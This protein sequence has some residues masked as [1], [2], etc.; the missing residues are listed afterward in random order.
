[1]STGRRLQQA[2]RREAAMQDAAI[3][4]FEEDLRRVLTLASKRLRAL[5]G[6]WQA[7][8]KGRS[9]AIQLARVLALRTRARQVLRDAGFD[10]LAVS[11]LGDPLERLATAALRSSRIANAAMKFSANDLEWLEAWRTFRLADLLD[12]ADDAARA[13]QRVAL[14]G[15]LGLRPLSSLVLDVVDA[16][17]LSF[18]QARTIYDTAVSVYARQVGL[19]H[20]TGE[21]D[22]L[23][24]YAGPADLKTREFCAE[25]VGKV[26]SREEIDQLDNEQL[27]D[28]L[29]TGGG[30]N[31][32]HRWMRVSELDSE[33]RELY[34]TGERA[35]WIEDEIGRLEAAA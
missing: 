26:L 35:P 6:E 34:E 25:W 3:A 13:V 19:L 24:F 7:K 21:P 20:A 32:R 29:V 15:T 12:L 11:A 18:R 31:C 27:P 14:D 4:G 30:Y 23:F 33:L 16:L 1:M 28:V 5:L 17:E 9:R 10:S 2:V 22:E 8:P